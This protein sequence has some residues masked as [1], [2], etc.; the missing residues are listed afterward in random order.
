MAQCCVPC[1]LRNAMLC[2]LNACSLQCVWCPVSAL[3][4]LSVSA[5]CSRKY[6]DE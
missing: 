1:F 5:Y 2:Q 3:L 6:I 4:T